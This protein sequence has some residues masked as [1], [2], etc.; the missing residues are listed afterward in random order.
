VGSRSRSQIGPRSARPARAYVP[1]SFWM[2]GSA[3]FPSA[4]GRKDRGQRRG[5][6]AQSLAAHGSKST[7]PVQPSSRPILSVTLKHAGPSRPRGPEGRL[8]TDSGHWVCQRSPVVF[9]VRA[10]KRA[11][12]VLY[13]TGINHRPRVKM[14]H[15]HG[16]RLLNWCRRLGVKDKE[17]IEGHVLA[18]SAREGLNA[19]P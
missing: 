11:V 13:I 19:I 5:L 6:S 9:P 17:D 3:A 4:P 18:I 16:N 15:A 10:V 14:P 8:S 2:P 7:N 1:P 12:P